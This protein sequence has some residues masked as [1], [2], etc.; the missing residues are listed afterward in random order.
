MLIFAITE[1][2]NRYEENVISILWRAVIQSG[3][4]FLEKLYD[5]N[6]FNYIFKSKNFYENMLISDS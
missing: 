1:N 3:T 2:L 6:W 5:K 4:V